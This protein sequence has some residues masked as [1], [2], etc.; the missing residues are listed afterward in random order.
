MTLLYGTIWMALVLF[1][2][3]EAGKGPLAAGGRAAA[4]ARPVWTLGA[5]V[6][7]LHAVLAF[8]TRYNWDH[9]AAVV[10]TAQQGAALYGFAWRGSIYVNY[11]FLLLWLT[12]AWTWRHWVWRAFVLMMIVNGAIIFARP[13]A[14][15]FGVAIVC[16]LVWAWMRTPRT[17]LPLGEWQ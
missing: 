9:E 6:G 1:V 12:V 13:A 5:I 8:A 11:I 3:A 17:A 14:R 7:I 10:A 4:W 2:A 15:P 16:V